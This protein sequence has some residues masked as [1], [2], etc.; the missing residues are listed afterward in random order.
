MMSKAAGELAFLA[1]LS[2]KHAYLRSLAAL[3]WGAERAEE[4]ACVWEA[5]EDAYKEYPTSIGFSYGGPMHAGPT[6]ILQLIPKNTVPSHTWVGNLPTTGDRLANCLNGTH[7]LA[8]CFTL[9]DA[10]Q[11]KWKRGLARLESISGCGEDAESREQLSVARALAILFESG[12]NIVEFYL[13]REKLGRGEGDAMAHLARMREIFA[14]EKENSRRLC[15][16]CEKDGRL[17]FHGEAESYQ[18]HKERLLHRIDALDFILETEFPTVEARI[19][20]GRLP[21]DYY[22]KDYDGC[23]VYRVGNREEAEWIDFQPKRETP[24]ARMRVWREDHR[25]YMEF[26][27]ARGGYFVLYP[28]RKLGYSNPP[29][30]FHP[31]GAVEPRRSYTGGD[32]FLHYGMNEEEIAAEYAHYRVEIVEAGETT[33]LIVSLHEDE[34]DSLGM[35]DCGAVCS[36]GDTLRGGLLWDVST[37]PSILVRFYWE[38]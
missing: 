12:T 38:K 2:D 14:I 3:T 35:F 15:A 37:D 30:S 25:V 29:L 13:L 34:L 22:T 27:D 6:W 19:R 23:P 24:S 33:D 9:C 4:A 8:E 10:M 28:E 11:S 20:E 36:S 5:F 16:L 31:N 1:D 18:F 21:F 26:Q 7:T 17:G 32:S